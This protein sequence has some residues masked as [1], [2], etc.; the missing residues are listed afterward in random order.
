MKNMHA[1]PRIHGEYPSF[2]VQESVLRSSSSE[3]RTL[4]MG[5]NPGW[6]ET[7]EVEFGGRI[8]YR[9]PAAREIAW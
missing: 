3:V 4:F 9:D 2:S 8:R 5:K 6:A 7:A 1:P